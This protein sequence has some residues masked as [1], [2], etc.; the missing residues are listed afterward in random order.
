MKKQR[1]QLVTM[2]TLWCILSFVMSKANLNMTSYKIAY[3]KSGIG[4]EADSK[5]KYRTDI[6]TLTM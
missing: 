3:R 1:C 6:K 4:A 5:G 2:G